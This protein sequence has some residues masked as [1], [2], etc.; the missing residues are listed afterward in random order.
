MEQVIL[1]KEAREDLIEIGRYTQE[2]WGKE[3]R[4]K[5]LEQF[6]STLKKLAEGKSKG[7]QRNELVGAPLSYGEGSPII[8]YQETEKGIEVLRILHKRMDFGK[9]L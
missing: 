2:K 1:S 6:H 4:L 8:F 5:Y 7:R 3:Q 9:Y